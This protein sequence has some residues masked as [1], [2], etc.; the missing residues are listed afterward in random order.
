MDHERERESHTALLVPTV[1]GIPGHEDNM[2]PVSAVFGIVSGASG[3]V[4]GAAQI[5][6][7]L[8][9]LLDA[10]QN[11]PLVILDLLSS[12]KAYQI[13]WTKIENWSRIDPHALPTAQ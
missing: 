8:S 2:D 12:W 6:R 10:H 13:A 5:V 4:S 9:D 11:V 1:V 7:F 3:I